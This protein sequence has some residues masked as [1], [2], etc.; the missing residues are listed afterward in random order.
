MCREGLSTIFFGAKQEVLD[1]AIIEIKR[2]FRAIDIAGCRNGYFKPED[3]LGIVNTIRASKA[4]C[5]FIA[6]SS[7]TKERLL[8]AIGMNWA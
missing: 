1:K 4:D 2:C 8:D 7:P 6:I 3:E 5:L